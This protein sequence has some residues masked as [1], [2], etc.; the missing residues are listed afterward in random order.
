MYHTERFQYEK[1]GWDLKENIGQTWCQIE[2]YN[3]YLKKIADLLSQ[4]YTVEKMKSKAEI[5]LVMLENKKEDH[6][7]ELYQ[8]R[9]TSIKSQCEERISDMLEQLSLVQKLKEDL[10][11]TV[12]ILKSRQ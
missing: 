5:E 7:K 9:L 8:K 1:G 2:I 11:N 3:E 4:I 10:E 6:S 12:P